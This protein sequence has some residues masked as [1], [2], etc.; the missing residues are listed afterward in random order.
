MTSRMRGTVDLGEEPPLPLTGTDLSR[1]VAVSNPNW[2][3][4]LF[5]FDR[6]ASE[7]PASAANQHHRFPWPQL[8]SLDQVSQTKNLVASPDMLNLSQL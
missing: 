7:S 6:Q 3:A 2:R 5:G 1:V 4:R 8:T